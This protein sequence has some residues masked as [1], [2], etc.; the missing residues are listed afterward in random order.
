MSLF[1]NY[2]AEL[3][4]FIEPLPAPKRGRREGLRLGLVTQFLNAVAE[5][6]SKNKTLR[7][8]SSIA[9]RLKR[10]PE[11]VSVSQRTLRRYVD[12][13]IDLEM[14][15]L[16]MTPLGSW[17]EHFGIF[18]PRDKLNEKVLR[19]KAFELLRHHAGT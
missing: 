12:E 6:L 19:E 16:K 18:P 15:R 4:K 10:R 8:A 9:D 13:L 2:A 14:R 1:P 17:K 11:Y 3:L 7:S 5:T